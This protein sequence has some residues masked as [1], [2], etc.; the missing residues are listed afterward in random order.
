MINLFTE[1]FDRW[2]GQI[3]KYTPYDGTKF[4]IANTNKKFA[5]CST[6][7]KIYTYSDNNNQT[8]LF[9]LVND[10]QCDS[11]NNSKC[12]TLCDP[13]GDIT[14]SVRKTK[15]SLQVFCKTLTGGCIAIECNYDYKIAD[16]KKAIQ[17][18]EGIPIDQ[19]RLIYNGKEMKDFEYMMCYGIQPESTCCLVLRLRGGMH[20]VSSSHNDYGS[21]STRTSTN[22]STSIG[23][24]QSTDNQSSCVVKVKIAG[25]ENPKYVDINIDV[26]NGFCTRDAF[27]AA[28]KYA[29]D[30]DQ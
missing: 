2:I 20:H 9:C 29:C 19:Q 23:P 15:P 8:Y 25:G 13:F 1:H 27:I 7:N 5:Y 4:N 22:Y 21:N 11:Y 12:Q 30:F 16:M 10:N 17:D 3:D 6:T 14:I 24:L 26:V 28:I 18:K